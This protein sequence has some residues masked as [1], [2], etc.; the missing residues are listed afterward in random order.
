MVGE[1]SRPNAVGKEISLH[2]SQKGGGSVWS[3]VSTCSVPAIKRQKDP[4]WV[5][6]PRK[7][8]EEEISSLGSLG[9]GL[10]IIITIV[11]IINNNKGQ[12][13]C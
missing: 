8:D 4:T 12:G 10:A 1:R 13:S 9:D 6:I 5:P 2:R 3:G 11:I 7:E